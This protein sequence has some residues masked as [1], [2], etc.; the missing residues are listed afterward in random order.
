MISNGK[1]IIFI[2]MMLILCN[3]VFWMTVLS[4]QERRIKA[5]EHTLASQRIDIKRVTS[6]YG[7]DE[8]KWEAIKAD[9]DRVIDTRV[10]HIFL[11]PEYAGRIAESLQ[12]SGLSM[13]GKMVFQPGTVSEPLGLNRYGTVI[14]VS[15][16]YPQFKRFLADLQNFPEIIV[17]DDITLTRS[18]AGESGVTLSLVIDLFFKGNLDG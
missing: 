2:A 13:T 9:M 4:R 6:D 3:G 1:K 18:A 14:T 8:K 7:P 17:L 5:L 10:P 15:G 12:K 11:L 16:A